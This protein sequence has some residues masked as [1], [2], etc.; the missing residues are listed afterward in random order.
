MNVLNATEL[1]SLQSSIL[2]YVVFS[3]FLKN[4]SLIMIQCVQR[5]IFS[6][7]TR[8]LH[9]RREVSRSNGFPAIKDFINHLGKKSKQLNDDI[10]PSRIRRYSS[11]QRSKCTRMLTLLPVLI[12]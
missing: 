8:A 2:C 10:K 7:V 4:A 1:L 12:V 11:H 3:S 6:S 9:C 5:S